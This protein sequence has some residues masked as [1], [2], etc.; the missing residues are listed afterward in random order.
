MSKASNE[1]DPKFSDSAWAKLLALSG[2][3]STAAR[4]L[5]ACDTIGDFQRKL[6]RNLPGAIN[7]HAPREITQNGML[8]L[9][10]VI[11]S[12][13]VLIKA[14]DT[15]CIIY[16]PVDARLYIHD[17]S[18]CNSMKDYEETRLTMRSTVAGHQNL[19]DL[20]D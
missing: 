17:Y 18:N 8:Y 4:F 15:F 16:R 20:L 19:S 13:I 9:V 1:N 12:P 14:V 11:P 7:A 2:R 5:D 10:F 6:A 3:P